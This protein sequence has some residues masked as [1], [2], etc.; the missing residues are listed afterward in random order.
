M[1]VDDYPPELQPQPETMMDDFGF[2]LL[3]PNTQEPMLV[4][5][6]AEPEVTP[7][8]EEMRKQWKEQAGIALVLSEVTYEWDIRANTDSAL[9]SARAERGQVAADLFRLGAIDR[10]A[11]LE[12]MDFPSRHKILQRL[13]AE[14][15]GK[16]AGDPVADP[17]SGGIDQLMQ[18]M[19]E[20]GMPQET[21]DQLMQQLQGGGQAAPQG[22]N[23]PP[24]MTM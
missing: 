24:Q 16:S 1:V 3:D 8:L 13:A 23:F 10:E 6:D 19:A 11:L 9:P 18:M 21:L 20:M 4:D 7:E 15:T 14:V 5:P 12:A 2:P 22:G 17:S